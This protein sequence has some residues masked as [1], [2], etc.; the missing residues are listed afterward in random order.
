MARCS[1]CHTTEGWFQRAFIIGAS[2]A[3]ILIDTCAP[4]MAR[5]EQQW[6]GLRREGRPTPAA[7]GAGRPHLK[8]SR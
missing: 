4:C 5:R 3:P 2:P 8:V 1:L 7:G 6:G